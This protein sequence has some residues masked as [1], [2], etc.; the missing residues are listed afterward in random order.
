MR[1]RRKPLGRDFARRW[2]RTGVSLEGAPRGARVLIEEPDGAE[3]FAYWSLLT[4]NGYE[5][6]WC[7]GPG[8]PSH[9]QC[10][11]VSSGHC[12]LIEHADVVVSSIGIDHEP[13]R[14]VLGAIR[15]LHPETPVIVEA[16]QREF[17]RWGDLF[18]GNWAL[19]TPVTGDALL[20]SVRDVLANRQ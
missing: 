19:R 18:D 2:P 1:L 9:G 20:G 14:D 3:A 13:C 15:R 12:E 6:E 7:P 16:T 8:R 4:D 10:P 11:L 17:T 5:V